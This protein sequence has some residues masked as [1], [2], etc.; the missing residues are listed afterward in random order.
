MQFFKEKVNMQEEPKSFS[1]GGN[2]S[3]HALPDIK[4]YYKAANITI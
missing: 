2:G 4:V 1:K 3:G